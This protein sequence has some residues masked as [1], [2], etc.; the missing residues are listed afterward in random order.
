M[1]K[2]D[3]EQ[4]TDVQKAARYFYLIRNSFAGLIKKQ[5]FHVSVVQRPNLL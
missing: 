5:H 3:P 2:T 4:L 1:T